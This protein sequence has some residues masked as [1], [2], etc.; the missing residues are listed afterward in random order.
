MTTC[1][2]CLSHMDIPKGGNTSLH[3]YINFYI[4]WP[5]STI[6]FLPEAC[7]SRVLCV[8]VVVHMVNELSFLPFHL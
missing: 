5:M 3:V 7:F 6:F 8:L 4:F 2:Q 1:L